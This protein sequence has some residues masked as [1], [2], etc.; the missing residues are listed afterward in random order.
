L[1]HRVHA[2]ATF[3]ASRRYGEAYEARAQ[4]APPPKFGQDRQSVPEPNVLANSGVQANRADHL[5]AD[6]GH[7]MTNPGRVIV[8]VA[9]RAIENGLFGDKHCVTNAEVAVP[10]LGSG[11]KAT[12][13]RCWLG[14][15]INQEGRHLFPAGV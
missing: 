2:S 6:D 9:I 14:R 5:T 15:S 11:G 7:D 10:I 13:R 12:R 3:V 1:D 4:D 8:F